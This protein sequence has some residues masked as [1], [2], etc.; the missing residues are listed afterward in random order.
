MIAL[1]EDNGN[2]LPVRR[3]GRAR[4]REDG[5][6]VF[7]PFTFEV[8]RAILDRL[9][10]LEVETGDTLILPAEIE[11]IEDIWR[12]DRIREDGRLALLAA[13]GLDG[14]ALPA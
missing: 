3:D 9:R 11:V 12:C 8:R 2:R 7:G 4:L 13:V 10:A 6:R 14:E 1:R 5:T